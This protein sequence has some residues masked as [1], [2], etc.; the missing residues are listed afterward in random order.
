V[1][2]I[3]IYPTPVASGDDARSGTATLADV[4]VGKVGA[5]VALRYGRLYDRPR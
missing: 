4:V 5:C 2:T 1:L 3:V